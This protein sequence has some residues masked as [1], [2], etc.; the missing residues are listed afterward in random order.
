MAGLARKLTETLPED[1]LC[2]QLFKEAGQNLARS[3]AAVVRKAGKELKGKELNL[4]CVGSMWNNWNKLRDGFVE[5]LNANANISEMFLLKMTGSA[6]IGAAYMAS[7]RLGLEM[8]KDFQKNYHAFY[9]YYKNGPVC[10]C[11]SKK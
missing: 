2:R 11:K 7:D 4:I 9:R 3:V 1:Q 6:A 8:P 5:W 10:P